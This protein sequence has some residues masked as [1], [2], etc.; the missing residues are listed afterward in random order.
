MVLYELFHAIWLLMTVHPW[1][2]GWDDEM[3]DSTFAWMRVW[4]V[5]RDHANSRIAGDCCLCL[6]V[7]VL[8]ASH[9]HVTTSVV[10]WFLA[11]SWISSM[12]TNADL[13]KLFD[14]IHFW[15]EQC[16]PHMPQIQATC[17]A[18]SYNLF[19]LAYSWG[20]MFVQVDLI[21]TLPT[22]SQLPA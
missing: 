1:W 18:S 7:A 6:T 20:T 11:R 13:S 10:S 17:P 15:L 2:D 4:Y 19:W 21:V 14:K 3:D 12:A 9:L 16:K 22:S 5:W 8:V